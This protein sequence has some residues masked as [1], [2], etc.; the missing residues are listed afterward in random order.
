MIFCPRAAKWTRCRGS[1]SARSTTS[2]ADQGRSAGASQ[3]T[4]QRHL[5]RELRENRDQLDRELAGAA[6][7]QR[8]LPAAMPPRR[9]SVSAA[10]T[11][12]AAT[13]AITRCAAA[14]GDRFGIL[15]ADV[16]GM[17][18]A[19]RDGDDP[20]GVHTYPGVADDP[21]EVLH[22]INGISSFSGTRRCMRRRYAVVDAGRGTIRMASAGHPLPLKAR[23]G[24]VSYRVARHGR[25]ACSGTS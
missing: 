4:Y 5:E 14:G 19:D 22:Y 25:C 17:A 13:P 11:R 8:L 10:T 21:R 18:P 23:C 12:P 24:E 2:P 6:L 7:M 20:R 1:S 3:R 16:S 9:R 15:V